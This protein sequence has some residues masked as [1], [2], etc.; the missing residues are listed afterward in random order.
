[1][2]QQLLTGSWKTAYK[3]ASS[4]FKSNW[5]LRD[6]PIEFMNQEVKDE[7]DSYLKKYPWEARILNWYWMRGE[8]QTKEEAY[9]DLRANFEAYLQKGGDLPRPGSKA[10][11]VYASVDQINQLEPEGI[12]FFKEI[13][14]LDYYGMFISDEASLFDFCDSKFALLKKITRIQEN[15]GISISDIE[16]LRIVGILQ[17]M[18]E[19]GV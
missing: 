4:F 1:M 3:M 5:S 14:G 15:Y 11:I 12:I 16:G 10:G 13:F 19:A 17:R 18:K 6:Y 9:A 2:K 7:S 8:G